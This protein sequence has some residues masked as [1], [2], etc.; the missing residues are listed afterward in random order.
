[1]VICCGSPSGLRQDLGDHP[2]QHGSHFPDGNWSFRKPRG[3]SLLTGPSD[4]SQED[5]CSLFSPLTPEGD[6]A[7]EAE[8][9]P[10]C[11]NEVFPGLSPALPTQR[12]WE[13][14]PE[15]AASSQVVL[16]ISVLLNLLST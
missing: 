5:L 16:S 13:K 12:F 4:P 8:I 10:A 1:M 3:L 7:S 2:V 15:Q 9:Q 14:Q 6:V 11:Q